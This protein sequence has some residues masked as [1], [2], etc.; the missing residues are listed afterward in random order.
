LLEFGNSNTGPS[1]CGGSSF[2]GI[3]R[4][5]RHRETEMPKYIVDLSYPSDLFFSTDT[6]E[7][8][9]KVAG[10]SGASGMGFGE[11]D[12]TWYDLTV[13]GAEKLKG[14]L[15]ALEITGSR[16]NTRPDED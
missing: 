6:E 9:R 13:T 3:I 4:Y 16:V 2:T 11:R 5:E 10:F 8:I 14:A 1:E 15:V 7:R 12:H